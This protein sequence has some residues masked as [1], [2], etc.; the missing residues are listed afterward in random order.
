MSWK[1]GIDDL[2]LDAAHNLL[3]AIARGTDKRSLGVAGYF[4]LVLFATGSRINSSSEYAEERGKSDRKN[5]GK[6]YTHGLFGFVRHPTT[7]ATSSRF[8]GFV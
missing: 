8:Q 6:L 2:L 1:R 7:L 4:G 3:I 5:R